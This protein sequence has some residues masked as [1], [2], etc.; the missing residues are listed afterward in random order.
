MNVQ[1]LSAVAATIGLSA[2]CF[3]QATAAGPAQPARP[4]PSAPRDDRAAESL[5]WRLG[6]QA[7]TFRDRT[8]FEAIETAGRLGLKYIELYPGQP[9]SPEDR[10]S[11]VGPGLSGSQVDALKARLAGAGVR[12]MSYGVVG[13][14]G[15]EGAA[16]RQFEFVRAMGMATLVAEPPP[17]ARDLAARLAGEYGIVVAI[18]NHPRPSIYWSPDAVLEAMN[19]GS[20]RLAACA[21][22]GHWTRSGLSAVDSLKKLVGHVA[23]LHFKDVAGGRDTVWGT[24]E[25]DAPGMLAELKRQGFR[26][27]VYVEY[28]DGRGAELEANVQRC[29]EFFDEAA[30]K[31]A[32]EAGPAAKPGVPGGPIPGG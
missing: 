28:E 18:H 22:T 19:G 23:E 17:E 3:G 26:G 15:D 1:V 12:A 13:I 31:L 29:I 32:A 14:V 8:A 27:P 21:D 16:R 25:S 2:V 6:V 4:A 20:P 11:E 9:L 24:G 30:R 10:A 7:W 5:G